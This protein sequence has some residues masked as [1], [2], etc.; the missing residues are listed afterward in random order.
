MQEFLPLNHRGRH[1]PTTKGCCCLFRTDR[2]E[3][4]REKKKLQNAPE[5]HNSSKPAVSTATLYL[6]RSPLLFSRANIPCG[7]VALTI[8]H[9]D[10]KAIVAR[11]VRSMLPLPNPGRINGRRADELGIIAALGVLWEDF[12]FLLAP[13]CKAVQ[14]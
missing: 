14:D 5:R 1:T 10:E 11:D 6:P 13:T 4:D 9:A 3:R 12:C 8:C 2:A 7:C